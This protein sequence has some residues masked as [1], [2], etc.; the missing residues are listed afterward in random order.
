MHRRGADL[1]IL[2]YIGFGGWAPVEFGVVVNEGEEL[3]LSR[4]VVTRHSE[5]PFEG[6]I[7][8]GGQQGVQLGCGFSL[9]A[10]N[11]ADLYP[12]V[13]Q[14]G[15]DALLFISRRNGHTNTC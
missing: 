12:Q 3:T 1:E 13:V 15:N 14:V 9:Q 5:F 4:R 8:D 10:L 2:L 6:F 11:R 7:E